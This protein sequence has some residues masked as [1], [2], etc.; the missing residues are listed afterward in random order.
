[1]SEI[2]CSK[3]S[4]ILLNAIERIL[5]KSETPCYLETQVRQKKAD[6]ANRSSD[7]SLTFFLENKYGLYSP[8]FVS[9]EY[10][11]F[12]NKQGLYIPA[13]VSIKL[14]KSLSNNSK[15]RH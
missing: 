10:F 9:M 8:A 13:F 6:W 11:F 5:E 15:E 2:R 14:E 3:Y 12:E 1:M 4:Y 7:S